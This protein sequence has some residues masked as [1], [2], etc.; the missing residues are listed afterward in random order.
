ME[1]S[2]SF[3]DC[4]SG[5]CIKLCKTTITII[6]SIRSISTLNLI[7]LSFSFK[8]V[9]MLFVFISYLYFVL[10]ETWFFNCFESLI[11]MR[12]RRAEHQQTCTK[13]YTAQHQIIIIIHTLP[14]NKNQTKP[15]KTIAHFNYS[16]SMISSS[17]FFGIHL[18][19]QQCERQINF[20]LWHNFLSVKCVQKF[21]I[22]VIHFTTP[23]PF[24]RSKQL[25]IY[26]F[27]GFCEWY[28]SC[29]LHDTYIY[30]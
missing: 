29:L 10:C 18:T 23:S 26:G 20:F 27:F 2:Q 17:Q 28:S 30:I 13:I 3:L 4:A 7:K 15:N 21:V 9:R 8:L 16:G 22:R 6:T 14:I 11:I 1:Q 25:K 5:E 24:T 19:F 12:Q